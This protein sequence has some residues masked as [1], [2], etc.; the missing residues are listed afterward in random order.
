MDSYDLSEDDELEIPDEIFRLIEHD[1][2]GIVP[3]REWH[4][5]SG[6]RR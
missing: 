3:R 2:K 5:Q 4:I 1:D 6:V